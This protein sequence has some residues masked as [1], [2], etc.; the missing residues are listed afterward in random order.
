MNIKKDIVID[1]SEDD[2]RKIIVDYIKEETKLDLNPKDILFKFGEERTE[3]CGVE[4]RDSV[5][6]G[7]TVKYEYES[8]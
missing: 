3:F 8:N 7:C 5:L 6:K 1:L 2:I 4:Y